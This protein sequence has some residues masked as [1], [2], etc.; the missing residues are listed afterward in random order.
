MNLQWKSREHTKNISAVFFFRVFISPYITCE[1]NRAQDSTEKRGFFACGIS[2]VTMAATLEEAEN[3]S[4]MPPVVRGIPIKAGPGIVGAQVGPHLHPPPVSVPAT[5]LD[6]D[7]QVGHHFLH[8][9]F[10]KI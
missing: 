3:G 2:K 7:E 10:L 9:A 8:M 5:I 6:M 4:A 1:E